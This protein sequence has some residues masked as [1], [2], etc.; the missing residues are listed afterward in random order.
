M[1][2][3]RRGG[4]HFSS[5]HKDPLEVKLKVANT[6]LPL[7]FRDKSREQ[8]LEVDFLVVNVPTAYIVILGRPTLHKIRSGRCIQHYLWGQAKLYVDHKPMLRAGN[9]KEKEMRENQKVHA[10]FASAM[11]IWSSVTLGQLGEAVGARFQDWL[12][13]STKSDLDRGLASKK[14]TAPI[15]VWK[16]VA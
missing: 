4:Q 8:N 14:F 6:L 13:F 9:I 2:S 1:T 5:L 10:P 15:D 11:T 16:E 12:G 3:D 7:R